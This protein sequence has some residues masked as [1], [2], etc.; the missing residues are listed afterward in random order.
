[1]SC[2]SSM[3]MAAPSLTCAFV[4]ARPPQ[5]K[6]DGPCPSRPSRA[7]S[8]AAAAALAAAAVVATVVAA[9][10]HRGATLRTG[11]SSSIGGST[12]RSRSRQRRASGLFLPARG[13]GC[14]FAARSGDSGTVPAT[15]GLSTGNA[16]AR[17]G[18][19]SSSLP[20]P[21]SA[22][23][24]H[25][26][27]GGLQPSRSKTI[28]R[29]RYGCILAAGMAVPAAAG[30]SCGET[31][32]QQR[33]SSRA[34]AILSRV[35]RAFGW[36]EASLGARRAGGA[37]VSCELKARVNLQSINC[38]PFE[39]CVGFGLVA[40][41]KARRMRTAAPALLLPRERGRCVCLVA[42]LSATALQKEKGKRKWPVRRD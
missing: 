21:S 9:A 20:L 22:S 37:I 31:D 18:H 3:D 30:A 10:V 5:A 12:F 11:S 42:H 36:E 33:K 38:P 13:G 40:N 24:L 41:P 14:C 7:R 17:L 23:R 16:P 8:F 28:L 34:V 32:G 25:A 35:A 19:A 6:L 39:G 15:L 2:C 1:M 27:L 29:P 26:K 4:H